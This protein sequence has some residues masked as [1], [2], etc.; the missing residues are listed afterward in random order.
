VPIFTGDSYNVPNS[1]VT[2]SSSAK[3][4]CLAWNQRQYRTFDGKEYTYP[5]KCTYIFAKDCEFQTF[6]IYTT[7][8]EPCSPTEKCVTQIDVYIGMEHALN[9]N[10]VNGIVTVSIILLYYGKSLLVVGMV[11]YR[12]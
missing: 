4:Y 5:S 7:N 10:R 8:G 9:L 2:S 6:S 11:F 12:I 1:F 3:E